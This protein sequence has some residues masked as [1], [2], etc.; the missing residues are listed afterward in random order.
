MSKIYILLEEIFNI[1]SNIDYN[2]IG[3]Y[4]DKQSAIDNSYILYHN[5]LKNY[6]SY[7]PFFKVLE[8]PL[9][10]PIDYINHNNNNVILELGIVD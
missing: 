2:I 10:T 4:L 3:I 5:S 9:N 6:S 7:K 8:Y 1:N